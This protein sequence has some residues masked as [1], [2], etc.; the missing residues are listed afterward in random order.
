VVVSHLSPQSAG[1]ERQRV[2][3]GY[4]FVEPRRHAAGLAD[5]TDPGR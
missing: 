3:L 1:R 5:L 2:Y 4:L